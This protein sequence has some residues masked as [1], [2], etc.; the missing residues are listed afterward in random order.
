[1]LCR[2]PPGRRV[3]TYLIVRASDPSHDATIQPT[4]AYSNT[5]VTI[6]TAVVVNQYNVI[7]VTCIMIHYVV[8]DMVPKVSIYRSINIY[9]YISSGK[10][11]GISITMSIIR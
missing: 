11:I 1:M 7:Q 2:G 8:L 5:N 3:D 10:K 6:R 4:P 9:I